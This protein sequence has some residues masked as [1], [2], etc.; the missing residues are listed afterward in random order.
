MALAAVLGVLAAATAPLAGTYLANQME[1]GAALELSGDGHFRYQLDYGAV[2]ESAS[3]TWSSDGRSVLLTSEPM[4]VAPAYEVIAD[5]PLP[6]GKLAI[7]VAEPDSPYFD[8][9]DVAIEREGSTVEVVRIGREETIDLTGGVAVTPLVPVLDTP[10]GR[11]ALSSERGHRLILKF[12]PN[13]LGLA[14]FDRESLAIDDGDLLLKRY[15]LTIRLE[16]AKR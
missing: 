1:V 14:R 11:V 12:H 7:H 9:L 10:G 16:S 13:D 6:R 8:S 2:S 3:G 5:E 15:E 4:P